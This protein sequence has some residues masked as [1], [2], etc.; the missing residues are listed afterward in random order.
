MLLLPTVCRL[1]FAVNVMLTLSIIFIVKEK[2]HE[3]YCLPTIVVFGSQQGNLSPVMIRYQSSKGLTLDVV[4]R[5]Q[6]DKIW[7]VSRRERKDCIGGH[8]C[9]LWDVEACAVGLSKFYSC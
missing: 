1:R 9:Q 4:S 2:D 5:A 8:W 7:K 3:S 6:S